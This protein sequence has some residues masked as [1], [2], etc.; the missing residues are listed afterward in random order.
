MDKF[1]VLSAA[2]VVMLVPQLGHAEGKIWPFCC[3]AHG[4]DGPY[5]SVK[6]GWT[7]TD[8][9]SYNTGAGR[10]STKLD[11]GQIMS[12][13]VGYKYGV[14]RY[15]VEGIHQASDVKSHTIAGTPRGGS[16][17]KTQTDAAMANAYVDLGTYI[18]LKPYVGAGLG[19]SRVKYKNYSSSST[20]P[21]LNDSDNAM[22]YQGMAGVSYDITPKWS[23]TAEYRYLGTNDAEVTTAGGGQTKIG[24]DSNNVLVG[25]RYT[26]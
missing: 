26:F 11:N 24:N 21:F 7:G 4:Q 8:N 6:G 9:H 17:G 13:A 22:A 1:K 15:E 3:E 12:G 14:M 5:V 2:A 25:L 19:Y 10:A 23:A 16:D 18:G 20:G